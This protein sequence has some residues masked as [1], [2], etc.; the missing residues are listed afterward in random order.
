MTAKQDLLSK[1]RENYD[2]WAQVYDHDAN[3]LPALEQPFMQKAAGDVRGLD[4]LDLGCGTGRHAAWLNAAGAVVQPGS[5]PH[6]SGDFVMAILNAGFTLGSIGEYAP[7]AAFAK[8]YP[9]AEKYVDWPMLIFF[10]LKS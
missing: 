8:R 9:R 6:Q 7:D 10:Q 3:P 5:L 4:V 1:V 2:R